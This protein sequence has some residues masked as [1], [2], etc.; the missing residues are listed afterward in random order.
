ME[1]SII[2][3]NTRDVLY[4]TLPGKSNGLELVLVDAKNIPIARYGF[5]MEKLKGVNSISYHSNNIRI[6]FDG[7]KPTSLSEL[8]TVVE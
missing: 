2:H 1:T 5:D 3:C 6:H 8:D 7:I 4:L